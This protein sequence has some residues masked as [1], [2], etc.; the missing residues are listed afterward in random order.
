[1]KKFSFFFVALLGVFVLQSCGEKLDEIC[2]DFAQTTIVPTNP[3]TAP[4]VVTVSKTLAAALKDQLTGKGVETSNVSS[5]KVNAITV[6]IPSTAGYTF[7]D[8]TT[9]EVFVNK[10]SIG[11]LPANATG[12]TQTFA[13]PSQADFNAVLLGSANVTMEFTATFTKVVPNPSTI[14]VKIPLNTCYKVL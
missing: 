5:V 13:S 10:I 2:F 14:D 4:G 8:M 7:A 1:M 9:A 6:T 11:K 12:L 3:V